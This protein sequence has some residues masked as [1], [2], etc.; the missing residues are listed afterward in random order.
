MA[1]LHGGQLDAIGGRTVDAVAGKEILNVDFATAQGLEEG[2][3]VTGARLAVGGGDDGDITEVD[4][5]LVDGSQARG[6]D[7]VV[8]CQ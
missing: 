4:Q 3:A 5:L 1:E 7:S 6:E 2:D 8:V